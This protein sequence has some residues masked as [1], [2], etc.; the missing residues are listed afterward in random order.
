[1]YP[2][3]VPPCQVKRFLLKKRS[4]P[5]SPKYVETNSKVQKTSTNSTHSISSASGSASTSKPASHSTSLEYVEANANLPI[6]IT[7]SILPTSCPSAPICQSTSTFVTLS[8]TYTVPTVHHAPSNPVIDKT[9]HNTHLNPIASF[10]PCVSQSAYTSTSTFVAP[11]TSHIVPNVH[12]T[13]SNHI[14][15]NTAQ[16]MDSNPT[17]TF[18]S[19]SSQLVGSPVP[20]VTMSSTLESTPTVSSVSVMNTNIHMHPQLSTASNTIE[21][22]ATVISTSTLKL[23][24]PLKIKLPLNI[25]TSILKATKSIPLKKRVTFDE[26]MSTVP[27]HTTEKTSEENTTMKN[28]FNQNAAHNPCVRSSATLLK[29]THCTIVQKNYVHCAPIS[30]SQ[31]MEKNQT[32]S[33]ALQH[34]QINYT[35]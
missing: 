13:Q 1:M 3:S 2:H 14:M 22:C 11:S 24:L 4:C 32:V 23:N 21:K 12:H 33:S 7:N 20:S 25:P 29:N 17:A 6:T 18:S 31:A 27:A 5:T 26:L 15:D 28:V 9:E 10:I 30:T 8:T 16:N 34:H 19:C 35:T